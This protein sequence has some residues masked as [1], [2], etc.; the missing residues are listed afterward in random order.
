MRERTRFI[1]FLGTP[2]RGS[3][4]ADWGQIA[5][6]LARV[7]MQ[8]SNKKILETLEVNNEVLDNI[9]EDFKQIASKG[10]F[11]VHSFQEARGVT[12]VR[13]L[14]GKVGTT[15]KPLGKADNPRWWT[16]SLPS[17]TFRENLRLS[18]ASMRTTCKWLGVPVEMIKYIAPSVVF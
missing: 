18:R 2:H 15:Q 5:S 9:H 11:K 12:G 17:S 10:K 1:V 7:A 3:G 14:E 6:S 13:G 16:T 4:C 8:D